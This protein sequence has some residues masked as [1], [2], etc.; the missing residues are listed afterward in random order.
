MT[1]SSYRL[2]LILLAMPFVA[3][4]FQ[5]DLPSEPPE[6]LGAAG[7]H[8]DCAPWDGG[9][10]TILLG[11]RVPTDPSKPEFPYLQ[12]SLYSKPTQFQVGKRLGFEIPGERG[13]A[14]YCLRAEACTKA[15]AVTLQFSKIEQDRLEGRFEVLFKGRKS[16]RGS[17]RAN[18]IPFRALCG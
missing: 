14:Q 15:T 3:C 5:A 4:A 8:D 7:F 6:G 18:R 12:I 1:R 13:F 9:A 2:L 17:F 16:I 10:T 11:Q